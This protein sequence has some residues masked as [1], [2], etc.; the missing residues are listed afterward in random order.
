[1]P[2]AAHAAAN[3]DKVAT[4]MLRSGEQL[5]YSEL[6]ERSI[7]LARF[8]RDAGLQSGDVVALFMDNDIRYHEVYWAAVRSGMYLC[9]VNKYLTAEEA[10]YIVND[11]GAKA[12]VVGASLAEAAT[13]MLP[14]LDDCP[15]RLAVSGD[16]A[17]YD[18]YET[19]IAD[20]SSELSMTN[21]SATS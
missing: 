3:P 11:S 9:A 20:V 10:A 14:D 16:I 13:G 12:V 8:L 17:G 2:M 7:K 18:R 5:T 1:M 19:A 4:T 15:I 21:R 6:N